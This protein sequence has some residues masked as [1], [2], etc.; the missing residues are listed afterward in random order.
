MKT[1]Y[2]YLIVVLISVIYVLTMNY[3]APELNPSRLKWWVF[4]L[5]PTIIFAL[6]VKTKNKTN[7]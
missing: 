2:Y 1:R 7:G 5:S 6:L 4:L 3:V